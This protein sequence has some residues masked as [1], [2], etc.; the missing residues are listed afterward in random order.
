[1][2]VE[3]TM[4]Q[5]GLTMTEGRIIRWIKNEGDKVLVDETIAEV[6]S[7][8]AT[9]DL[10]A[11]ASGTI[12]RIIASEG[13]VIPITTVIGY[14]GQE[15]EKMEVDISTENSLAD[16]EEDV[17]QLLISS[18]NAE[19]INSVDSKRIFISPR[20]KRAAKLNGLTLDMDNFKN[21]VGSGADARIIEKDVLDLVKQNTVK[22]TPLA[23]K[24]AQEHGIE[25]TNVKGTDLGEKV[26]RED[27]LN[28]IKTITTEATDTMAFEDIKGEEEEVL[29]IIPMKGIRK[30]IA[31]RMHYS[32]LTIPRVTHTTEVDMTE[33]S[34]LRKKLNNGL[35]DIEKISF[36][37]IFLKVLAIALEMHP[38]VNARLDGEEI[39]LLANSNIGIAVDIEA[40][41]VVPNIKNVNKKSL[42]RISEES[43]NL[44]KRAIVGK[45]LPDEMKGGTFTITNLGGKKYGIDGFTPIINWPE[46]AILGIGRMVEKPRF[47]G[48][49][50]CVRNVMILSL[51]FDHRIIDGGPAAEFLHTI[52][53][54]LENPMQL[55]LGV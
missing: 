52:K 43:K 27:V 8:K 35:D 2:S 46:A 29:S 18:K 53:E 38:Y 16:M 4:P 51:T 28:H 11:P 37:D 42:R 47:L 55:I 44:I 9:F 49:E 41:L 23:V 1:M 50:I 31:E 40:G 22:A 32:T 21:V 3:I 36:M 20:A 48:G 7:D 25:I 14:I 24:T 6:E 45:L 30:I 34:V 39:K 10:E 19:E 13:D 5:L 33:M 54:L 15:G 17:S 12:I 26:T